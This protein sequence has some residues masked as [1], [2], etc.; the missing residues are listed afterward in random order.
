[1]KTYE[2]SI[3]ASGLDPSLDD[4]ERLFYDSGCDDATVSFQKGHII[5][6]FA[7]DAETPEAAIES[8]LRDVENAGASVD[9]V[10]PDPLVSLADISS[11]TGATR[12]SVS[13]Y[14][15]GQRQSGFPSP[16]ARVTSPHPLWLWA[17]VAVWFCQLGKLH[18]SVADEAVAVEKANKELRLGRASPRCK[19]A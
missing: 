10:E 17:E 8:A 12:A 15:S 14:A 9:R 6:D 2:F 5:L 7:R 4:F 13:L 18:Q 11:R 19:V 3:V 16:V 1:M